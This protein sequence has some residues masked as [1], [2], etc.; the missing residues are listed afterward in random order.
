MPRTA[1]AIEGGG[2]YHVLNRG[3]GRKDLFRKDEDFIAFAGILAEAGE[4]YP[5]DLMAWC[6]MTN[7]WHLVVRPKHAESIGRFLGWVGVTHVRRHHAHYRTTGGGHLYQGRF[8]SFPVQNDH[9]F[10]TLCR[11]V[12]ANPLRAGLVEAAQDW[13]WSSCGQRRVSS[14]LVTTAPWPVERPRQWTRLVNQSMDEPDV[15]AVE[16]SITRGRPLG[17]DRWTTR[18][19][20][21]LGLEFTLRGRGRPRKAEK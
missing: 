4:R 15:T 5:V 17:D 19:A 14:P 6:L 20:A 12:E 18:T 11:Y 13:R 8:K 9:H 16:T 2:Y 1:R 7:H 21:R 10:L 3:N